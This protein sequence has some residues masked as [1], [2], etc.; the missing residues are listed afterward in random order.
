MLFALLKAPLIFLLLVTDIVLANL[1]SV[2]TIVPQVTIC[3]LLLLALLQTQDVILVD[4]FV[5]T[6][7]SLL[8]RLLLPMEVQPPLQ[9]A[10]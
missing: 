9:V 7:T 10:L 8:E 5:P 3:V 6:V 2:V 4:A 1:V